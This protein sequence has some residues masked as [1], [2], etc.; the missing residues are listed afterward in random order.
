MN[1]NSLNIWIIANVDFPQGRGGTP[2][3]R[4]IGVGLTKLGNK[5]KLLIPHSA[6]YVAKNQNTQIKGNYKGIEFVYFTKTTE[7]ISSEIGIALTK[8]VGNFRLGVRFLFSPKPDILLIY[9]YSFLDVG[10]LFLFAKLMGRKVIFDVCDE[11][12][13]LF[14]TNWSK[15]FFRWINSLQVRLSDKVMFKY[16]DGFLVVS[17]YLQDKILR[18][19]RGQKILNV[20]L[21]AEIPDK[22]PEP[23]I[24]SNNFITNGFPKL[25][26]VGSLISDEGIEML[27]DCVS[28]LRKKHKKIICYLFGDANN[29]SFKERIDYLISNNN[30]NGN[31]VLPGSLPYEQL[32]DVLTHFDLLVLPRPDSVISRAG[33]PGKLSEYFSSG[34]P[35][36]TTNFGDI[37]NY[38]ADKKNLFISDNN[39]YE[40]FAN[41]IEEALDN[42]DELQ[43]VGR[44]GFLLAKESFDLQN[45]SKKIHEFFLSSKINN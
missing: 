45:V 14:A 41:K 38:F 29:P 9:N 2:R 12:F 44:N 30:L 11:R 7:R 4:N 33:F 34:R 40:S 43:R 36:V 16:A 17:S 32:K 37:S 24:T 5:V 22:I 1:K 20:P 27:I 23:Q 42:K 18:V 25:A 26:Y 31:F 39:T 10:L 6:G 8:M 35:V 15:S 19:Y 28:L 3:I 21:V 13:D